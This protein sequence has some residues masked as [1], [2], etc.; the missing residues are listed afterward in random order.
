MKAVRGNDGT[1]TLIPSL[2]A[3]FLKKS[4]SMETEVSYIRDSN[5][6]VI[7]TV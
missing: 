6:Y 4:F 2:Y 7:H 3:D 1:G 5:N